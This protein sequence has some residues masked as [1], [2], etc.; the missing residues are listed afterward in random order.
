MKK[1]LFTLVTLF[2][3]Q[4]SIAQLGGRT[5]YSFLNLQQSPRQ[6]A[7]GGKV[8]TYYDYDS[9]QVFYNPASLNEQMKN[10]ASANYSNYLGEITYG[11]GSYTFGIGKK[12]RLFHVGFSFLN[13]GDIDGYDELGNQ[14]GTFKASDAAFQV[15]YADSIPNTSWKVGANLK[16][17][18]STIEAYSSSALATDIALFNVNKESGLNYGLFFRNIGFQIKPFESE[19][20]NL[21]FEIAFGISQKLKHLPLRWHFTFDNLQKWDISYKNPNRSE[22]SLDGTVKEENVGFLNNFTRHIIL[23]AELFPEKAISIRL[24]YN[25]RKGQELNIVDQRSFSGLTLGFGIRYN[26]F[27]FDFS[28]AR[29]SVAANATM[30]GVMLKL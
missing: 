25:F 21:P 6:A 8:F 28:H 4:L 16:Y 23:G 2:C 11:T 26:S 3:I 9:N 27:R 18:T 10:R 19:K 17:I 14:T 22:T 7:L 29:Y 12:K 24:G 13:Y 20:E 15:G 1:H 30:V 5:L